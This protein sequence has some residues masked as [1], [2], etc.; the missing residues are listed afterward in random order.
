MSI[1]FIKSAFTLVAL[2]TAAVAASAQV[3]TL[4]VHHFLPAGSAAQTM[5]IKP[6]CDKIAA[7]SGEKMKCQ[8]YPSMQLGGT[9]P[10]LFDQVKDGVV[11][12]IWVLPGYMAGRFPLSEVFELPFMMQSPEGTS[13]ALWDFVAQNPNVA[14]E[15]KDVHLL[16]LHVH[17]DGVFH[18]T[19]KPIKTLADLKGTKLRAP[20]RQTNKLLAALGATPVAMPVPQV[21]EALSKSVIDGALVPYE[22]VPSV[23]IQELAKFHSETDPV[24]P[25]IYT[26]TFMFAMNK[27]K[28]EG[29]APELK[30]VIDANSGQALSGSI[31]KA[32]LAADSIGK[33]LTEKNA[34]NVIPASELQGWKKIGEQVTNDWV[35][36]VTAKG[37]D[38]KK[39]LADARALIAKYA[40]K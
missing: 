4:K 33:K 21:S 27:A 2:A 8:I 20:T 1:K 14:A 38:G 6:W 13:K 26:A 3:V 28:Y 37:A 7:E 25:A 39:L 19:G 29:L 18:M 9:P 34:H 15:F 12:I 10:Q 16:A 35:A 5:F 36:D 40:A 31:G 11:D 32:F 24:E 22:V 23:K 17:G 30:K